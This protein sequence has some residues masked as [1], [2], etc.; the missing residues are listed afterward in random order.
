MA[1]PHVKRLFAIGFLAMGAA[2][3]GYYGYK[4]RKAVNKKPDQ[5]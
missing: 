5:A 4:A 2:A 3:L 1:N